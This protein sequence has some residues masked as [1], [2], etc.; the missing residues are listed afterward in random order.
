LRG[1]EWHSQFDQCP[2]FS[3]APELDGASEEFRPLAHRDDAESAIRGGSD[4]FP[5]ILDVQF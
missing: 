2:A 3:W 4:T 5:V 1:F